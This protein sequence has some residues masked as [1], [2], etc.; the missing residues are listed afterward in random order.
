M[1]KTTIV[2]VAILIACLTCEAQVRDGNNVVMPIETYRGYRA[3]AVE[4]RKEADAVRDD[5]DS[6]QAISDSIIAAQGIRIKYKDSLLVNQKYEI[7]LKDTINRI[8]LKDKPKETKIH[9]QFWLGVFAG[10]AVQTIETIF[11]LKA[12]K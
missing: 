4:L 1:F 3:E 11:I 6:L 10:A 7:A 9:P 12:L 2:L 5:C 8:I